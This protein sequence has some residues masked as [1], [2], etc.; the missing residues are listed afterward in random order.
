MSLVIQRSGSTHRR[1]RCTRFAFFTLVWAAMF[2]GPLWSGPGCTEEPL[3]GASSSGTPAPS[4]A[5]VAGSQTPHP[6]AEA[7]PGGMRVHIDPATGRFVPPPRGAAVPQPAPAAP[8]PPMR[9]EAVPGGGFKL[10]TR[11]RLLHAVEAAVGSD[12]N[13][14][15]GCTRVPP[16]PA[17]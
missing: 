1:I 17:E 3:V 16:P 8:P 12:G 13:E 7:T 6:A 9:Q 11:G 14:K 2:P 4:E 5:S 10:D 15:V